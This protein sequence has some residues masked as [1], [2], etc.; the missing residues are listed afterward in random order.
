MAKFPKNSTPKLT[1]EL[2]EGIAQIIGAG[3]YIETAVAVHGI[4][5]DTFYRWL[6]QAKGAHA[7]EQTIKLSDAV[8]KA[9]A[10]AEERDLDIVELF[11]H[12]QAALFEYQVVR[13]SDG[14]IVYDE[15]GQ[16]LQ[17]IARDRRGNPILKQEEIKP[18]WKA[19]AW[20]LERRSPKRWGR[21]VGEDVD[22]WLKA[23]SDTDATS[24]L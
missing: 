11:A 10:I 14:S 3:N 18:D 23:A 2:I 9:V 20:R 8:A 4:S 5:K 21:H 19:A 17:E 24:S 16:P 12:G 22:S 1:D 7:N 13:D 6:R 15:E